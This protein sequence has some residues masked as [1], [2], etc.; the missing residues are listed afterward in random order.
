MSPD[1]E[2]EIVLRSWSLFYD[3]EPETTDV[4]FEMSCDD[5]WKD[6]IMTACLEMHT[7]NI[8]KK[9]HDLAY[10]PVRVEQIKEKFGSLRIYTTGGDNWTNGVV[11]MAE[12][13]SKFICEV[14]GDRGAHCRKGFNLKTLSEKIANQH[15]YIPS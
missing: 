2:K 5:G 1:I 9:T 14:T 13:M 6:I 8:R 11:D 4:G 7:Y 3:K 15:G 12:S 10:N